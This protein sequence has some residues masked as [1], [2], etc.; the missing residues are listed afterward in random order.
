MN[1]SLT[2]AALSSVWLCTLRVWRH[3]KHFRDHTL[4]NG[5]KWQRCERTAFIFFFTFKIKWVL[6]LHWKYVYISI[7][8]GIDCTKGRIHQSYPLLQFCQVFITTFM[9]RSMIVVI[10]SSSNRSPIRQTAKSLN[11]S[12]NFTVIGFLMMFIMYS[13]CDWSRVSGAEFTR[14]W[15]CLISSVH[16]FVVLYF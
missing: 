3:G 13:D 15:S 1:S 5:V 14:F 10:Q 8:G 16:V 7:R 6:T 9:K 12:I 11:R 4:R 2:P